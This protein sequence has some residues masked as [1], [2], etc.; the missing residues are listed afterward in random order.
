M[1]EQGVV[2]WFEEFSRNYLRRHLLTLNFHGLKESREVRSFCTGTEKKRRVE[3]K[4]LTLGLGAK[5]G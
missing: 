5:D 2:Y 4:L 3:Q 1:K